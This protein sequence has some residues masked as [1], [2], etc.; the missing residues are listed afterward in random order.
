M[1]V[2]VRGT[3]N[4]TATSYP[5]A[6]TGSRKTSWVRARGGIRDEHLEGGTWW[7]TSFHLRENV[8]GGSFRSS[9]VQL[10]RSSV[11]VV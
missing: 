6:L 3:V 5:Q 7:N 10:S 9:V 4:S 2:R 8:L 1:T 11:V